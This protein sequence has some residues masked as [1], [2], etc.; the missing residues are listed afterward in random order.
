MHTCTDARAEGQVLVDGVDITLLDA[1]WYRS[2]LGV[3][4]QEP[5]LF[6]MNVTDNI[7][8]GCPFT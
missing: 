1:A 7:C 3:V 5:R 8:Y 2:R 4:S 6:S